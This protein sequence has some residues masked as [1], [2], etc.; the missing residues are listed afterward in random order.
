MANELADLQQEWAA[1]LAEAEET[2]VGD[3]LD[4]R[5][6]CSES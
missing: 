5:A 3:G 2:S 4:E 6:T 1:Y